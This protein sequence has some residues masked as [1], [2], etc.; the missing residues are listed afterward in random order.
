MHM[1]WRHGVPRPYYG[2][3]TTVPGPLV[4]RVKSVIAPAPL[5]GQGRT[6][7]YLWLFGF[8]VRIATTTDW[9]S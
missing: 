7:W 3:Q 6:D 9:V 8:D 5:T 4:I 2:V 1:L